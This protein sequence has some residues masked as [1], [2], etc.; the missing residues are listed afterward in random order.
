VTSIKIHEN[1]DMP[2]SKVRDEIQ[3]VKACCT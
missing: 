2:H 3:P 1:Q